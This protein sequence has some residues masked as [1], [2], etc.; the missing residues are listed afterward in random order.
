M[1]DKIQKHPVKFLPLPPYEGRKEALE[2]RREKSLALALAAKMIKELQKEKETDELTGLPNRGAFNAELPKLFDLAKKENASIALMYLDIDGLKRTNEKLGHPT[3]DKLIQAVTKTFRT[4]PG[5]DENSSILRPDD[6]LGRFDGDEFWVIL[7][8]YKPKE[9]QTVEELNSSKINSLQAN[10]K[11]NAIEI[12]IP[13]ELH[14]GIS[15]GIAVIQAKDTIET[16]IE[17]ADRELLKSKR[18]KN[19]RLREQGINFEDDRMISI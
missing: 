6:I 19:D 13:E 3:G 9:G 4:N 11:K 16:L 18:D 14:V 17:R 2:E 8:D 7:L 5:K 12:G 10:F 15:A 1:D